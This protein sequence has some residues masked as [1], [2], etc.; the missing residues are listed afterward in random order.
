MLVLILIVKSNNVLKCIDFVIETSFF[1]AWDIM[2]RKRV[3]PV[4]LMNMVNQ[5]N[6]VLWSGWPV[7]LI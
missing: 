5:A 6:E 7:I 2:T 4:L 3:F 1:K